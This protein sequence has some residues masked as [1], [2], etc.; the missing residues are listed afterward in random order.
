MSEKNPITTPSSWAPD[1]SLNQLLTHQN[2]ALLVIMRSNSA[3]HIPGVCRRH[4]NGNRTSQ[5][6]HCLLYT[7]IRQFS[8]LSDRLHARANLAAECVKA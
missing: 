7:V 2:F 6:D 1:L 8:G 3:A 5:L 4:T